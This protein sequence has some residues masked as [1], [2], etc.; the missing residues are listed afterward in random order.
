MQSFLMALVECSVAMSVLILLFIAVTPLLE[1]GFAAKW[2]YYAWLVL[3]IGLIIP[4][5]P[6]LDRALIQVSTPA[7]PLITTQSSSIN[8]ANA[9]TAK[10]S[11]NIPWPELAGGLWLAGAIIVLAEHSWKHRRFVG[12]VSRWSE[13]VTDQQVL[14]TLQRLKA[15]L[16]ISTPVKMQ[17]CSCI[18]S[19]MT[20]GFVCPVVLLPAMDF[21]ADELSFILKHELVHC[22]RKDL[23]YKGLVLIATAMHWFNP[24][25][26]LMARAIAVQ[27]EISCDAAVV[28]NAGVDARRRYSETIIGVIKNHSR[29]QTVLSTSFYGGKGSMKTRISSIM[30]TTTKKAGIAIICIAL[31]ATLGAG[32]VFAV[33]AH[34]NHSQVPTPVF[35]RNENGQTYG[36]PTPRPGPVSPG[37]VPDLI[38]A[39]GVDG[40]VGYVRFTDL[41]GPQPKNPQEA[42]A[43]SKKNLASGV[44]QI[45]L[46]AVDGKTVIGVFNIGPG[47]SSQ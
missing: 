47:R 33:N 22:K 15:E 39:Q 14:G 46:Y 5:R 44:R 43:L 9:N 11:S 38:K 2:R 36:T 20:I 35:P 37:T 4:F 23:W 13:P 28:Q 10:T 30:D 8:T 41:Q 40:T 32:T 21:S 24:V 27:C 1:S 25:V 17:V 42:V 16:G 18:T 19:P 3:V 45:P 6:H 12:M 31:I 7:S 34:S 29:I 26:Y